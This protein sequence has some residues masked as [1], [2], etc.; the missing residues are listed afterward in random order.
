MRKDAQINQQ[1]ILAAAAKLFK[2]K[3]VSTVSM[4]DI[5]QTAGI[6]TGTLYRNFPNKSELCVALSLEYIQQFITSEQ[7]RLANSVSSATKQFEVFLTRWLEF[8]ERRI[9]LLTEIETGPSV[10]TTF[11]HSTLYQQLVNLTMQALKPVSDDI[12]E[13]ELKF[14]ADMLISMLK[15]DSYA[16]QREQGLTRDQITI[17]IIHLMIKQS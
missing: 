8:R 3:K 2:E 9:Q 15:S 17:N 5:A 12:S 11:Y 16:Y 14:R 1:K 7:V 4:K 6:G 13:T 10:M